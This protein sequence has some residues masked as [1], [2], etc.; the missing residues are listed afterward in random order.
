VFNRFA[1]T[2]FFIW[3]GL[4]IWAVDFLFV[5]VFAAIA[6]ARGFADARIAGMRV[7]QF[8]TI[9]VTLLALAAS[10]ITMWI[11]LRRLR[12][13]PEQDSSLTFIRFLA[14]ALGA[15]ATLAIIWNSL[16]PIVLRDQC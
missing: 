6:C 11:M 7:I 9:L 15:L 5:Y 3:S 2:A 1:P 4:L 10:A 8:V 13:E 16:P 14:L 12:H